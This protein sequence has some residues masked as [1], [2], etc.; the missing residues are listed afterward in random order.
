MNIIKRNG[1]KQEVD[2][3]KITVRIK[4]LSL[5]EPAL[6]INP[7]LVAQKVVSGLHDGVTTQALDDLAA[8][9]AI[10][11]SYDHPDYGILAARIAISN[12]HKETLDSYLDTSTLLFNH[13]L[14]SK[15]CYDIICENHTL[16]QS[17]INYENDYQYDYFGI[18]TLQKSYLLKIKDNI[19]ERI[20]HL[21][22]RV[23]VGIHKHNLLQVIKT[24]QWLSA[25]YYTLATPTLYNSGTP[26]PQLASCFLLQIQDDSVDGIY[27]TLKQSAL[28]SKYC[29]GEGI[30]IHKVRAKGS[31]IRSTNGTSN[32]I[33]PMLRS[34]NACAEHINQGSKRN[35][36][37]AVYLE[38][39]HA[40]I[41]AFL[42]CKKNH[43]VDKLRARDLFYALWI[44]NLFMERVKNNLNWSL[45]CP[46]ECPVLN[47]VYGDEYVK[48][49][50]QYE[51][52]GKARAVIKAQ[53]LWS[54]IM[55]SL[56]ETGGPYML[57]KDEIN[58]HNNQSNLGTIQSSNL[59]CEICEYT[60]PEEISVCTLASIALPKC[61]IDGVFNH[62]LLY[63]ITYHVVL[64][65]NQ[66]IDVNFY[67]LPESRYSN[68]KHRP[69]GIGVQG[70]ADVFILLNMPFDSIE[71]KQL[72]IEIFETMYYAACR[73]SCD[74]SKIHG[75]YESF[76]G[77]PASRGILCPDMWHH[78]PSNRWPFNALRQDIIKDGLRNSLLL[79]VVP[80]ASTS[81][82]LGN[83]ECI[84]PITSNVYA[85]R[86]LAGEF[87]VIN[88][89]LIHCLIKLGLW[90]PE[91]KNEII[92][93]NGSIQG[94]PGIPEEIQL[95]Y[96][97]AYE[98]SMK[99][100]IDMAS[101]RQKFICQSQSFNVF[102]AVPTK[103]KLTSMYFYAYE[104]QLKTMS[105][106]IRTKPSAEPIK[107]AVCQ[108]MC[109][110][111]TC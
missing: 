70:L 72:N 97:T 83:T 39:H 21:L 109:T 32:G 38:P 105:Y 74:L 107:F 3:N 26:T 13:D 110:S 88:K 104:K 91:I 14:L 84:E 86:V 96:R 35:G 2:F 80:T 5:K 17:H 67:P 78:Q 63:D 36:S 108:E 75:P 54:L 42:E 93:R 58:L 59:C 44:S 16:L 94:I 87:M 41:E 62:Q 65:L 68:L 55:T 61:V 92:V 103:N 4:Q 20:Q 46:D 40:D 33:V 28:I 71:S 66:V 23:A 85:R 7:I 111:C 51:S 29:G 82:I 10:F 6:H 24:Y 43:G 95:L 101:D 99:D 30:S 102:M 53:S 69:I 64:D 8:E 19:V 47:D 27:N 90:T 18:K 1:R 57:N 73:A 79:T 89:H 52:T 22:M 31:Y 11:L 76:K 50:E 100:L 34:F 106:Y 15:E 25:K 77:S 12:L 81:Q 45:F 9:T 98:L 49:Y 48:L 37:I 56:I 60:S